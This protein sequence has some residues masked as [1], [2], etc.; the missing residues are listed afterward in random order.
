MAVIEY[1]ERQWPREL[2]KAQHD[3]VNRLD[4]GR[5]VVG[6]AGALESLRELLSQRVGAVQLGVD[7]T[8]PG[9]RLVDRRLQALQRGAALRIFDIGTADL[10]PI[11][12]GRAHS[13]EAEPERVLRHPRGPRI[14]ARAGCRHPVGVADVA[15]SERLPQAAPLG[16]GIIF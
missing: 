3:S 9:A 14:R 8:A 5:D 16:C 12:K 2:G 1:V 15:P 10:R 7:R 13:V 6:L 11:V 4:H